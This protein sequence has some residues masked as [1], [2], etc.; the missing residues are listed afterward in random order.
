MGG[1]MP[2]QCS[3][4]YGGPTGGGTTDH[5]LGR[6][7]AEP[8]FSRRAG[9]ETA[10]ARHLSSIPV[11]PGP[12][13][14][15]SVSRPPGSPRPLRR[16]AERNRERVLA[17]ARELFVEQGLDVGVDEIAKRAGVGM[18]TLYRR[19]PNKD[20]LIEAIL[21]TVVDHLRSIAEDV[22]A[23]EPPTVA[24][25]S[26]FI[27]SITTEVCQW[28]FLSSRLWSGRTNELLFAD[29]VPL[30]GE[31]FTRAQQAGAV[32]SDVVLS[33]L[34]V[35]VRSMRVVLDLTDGF[36]PEVWRRHLD[37]LLDGLRPCSGNAVLDVGPMPFDALAI[38]A[39]ARP[40]V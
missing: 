25:R 22:L 34:I 33:D 19:F 13:R 30:I 37:L 11:P 20:A 2:I 24:L 18:G 29:V 3:G 10:P 1:P 27:R 39:A 38:S 36:A 35:L 23:T 9:A 6:P 17:A 4:M 12:A 15:R 31:M 28:A 40:L 8:V 5:D 16:D 32:R 21:G 14:S 26:F 7:R